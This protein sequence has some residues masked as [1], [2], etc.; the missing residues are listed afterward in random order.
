MQIHLPTTK[1]K[2]SYTTLHIYIYI[3]SFRLANEEKK[4][5]HQCTIKTVPSPCPRYILSHE[6]D[7]IIR[8][9]TSH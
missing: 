8:K 1:K 9:Q 4:R 2:K 5:Y 3:T 6:L 7:I